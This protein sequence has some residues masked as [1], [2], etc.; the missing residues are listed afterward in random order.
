[1]TQGQLTGQ[2]EGVA[3]KGT[4]LSNLL[5]EMNSIALNHTHLTAKLIFL[6]KNI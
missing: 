3:G 4:I 5:R 6:S 1:M 2:A